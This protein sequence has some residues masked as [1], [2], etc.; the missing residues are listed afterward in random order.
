MDMCRRAGHC[1]VHPF[2]VPR[3]R[4]G[5]AHSLAG[6]Q[7][8]RFERDYARLKDLLEQR[9]EP[10][11]GDDGSTAETDSGKTLATIAIEPEGESV[12]PVPEETAAT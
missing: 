1:A 12:G 11:G 6:A 10:A 2:Q 5:A 3:E 8:R 7:C 9:V 4:H